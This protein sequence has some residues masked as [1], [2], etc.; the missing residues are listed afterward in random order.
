MGCCCSSELNKPPPASRPERR[1]RQSNQV[2]LTE[3]SDDEEGDVDVQLSKPIIHTYRGRSSNKVG[4]I[5][6]MQKAKVEKEL[7]QKQ[8]ENNKELRKKQELQL[9]EKLRQQKHN[10]NLQK[11]EQLKFKEEQEK[12]QAEITRKQE[13]LLQIEME[14]RRDYFQTADE[15]KAIE[16]RTSNNAKDVS[17]THGETNGNKRFHLNKTSESK[18]NLTGVVKSGWGFEDMNVEDI[19]GEPPPVPPTYRKKD[20]VPNINEFSL[21]DKHAVKAPLYAKSSIARLVNY[22]KQGAEN[23]F[24][25]VR[26]F[27]SFDVEGYFGEEQL[28]SV[29]ADDVLKTGLTIAEGYAN[30]LAAMCNYEGIPVKVIHGLVKGYDYQVGDVIN[31]TESRIMHSWNAVY[32]NRNWFFIDC[33]WGA[34]FVDKKRIWHRQYQEFYFIVDPDKMIIDHFPFMDEDFRS[35]SKWQLLTSP[36]SANS[37][38]QRLKLERAALEWEVKPVTHTQHH[39]ITVNKELTVALEE[40]GDILEDYTIQFQRKDGSRNLDKFYFA[41]KVNKRSLKI[42]LRP[43]EEIDYLLNI[44]AQKSI[45]AAVM[46]CPNIIKAS[47]MYQDLNRDENDI[48]EASVITPP[49]GQP[50]TIYGQKKENGPLVGLYHFTIF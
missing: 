9:Q 18:F 7:K 47:V 16:A 50:F 28:Q 43:P 6:P 29:E 2:V 42:T 14:R 15:V 48:F 49:A 32:I 31:F 19:E 30:L 23:H 13:E 22:L 5:E 25:L 35:S 8:K 45:D 10:F 39:I 33:A 11:E 4:V 21:F 17:T 46:G 3:L 26:M 40:V 34:G 41:C 27:Y 12:V 1:L 24:Q 20:I 37:F 38:N 44:F 36:I